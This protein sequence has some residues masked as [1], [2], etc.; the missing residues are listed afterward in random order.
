MPEVLE[1]AIEQDEHLK[2]IFESLTLGNSAISF[3]KSV[4][5]KTSISKLIFG[6]NWKFKIKYYIGGHLLLKS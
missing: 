2:A 5:F 6:E 3:I 1:T 4:E